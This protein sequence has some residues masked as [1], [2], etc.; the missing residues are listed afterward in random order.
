MTQLES[1]T[2]VA[3]CPFC[4]ASASLP[5]DPREFAKFF[6]DRA[7]GHAPG[8]DL[9]VYARPHQYLALAKMLDDAALALQQRGDQS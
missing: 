9:A 6:R 8:Y 7:E 3:P 2:A 4:G 1:V 5:D